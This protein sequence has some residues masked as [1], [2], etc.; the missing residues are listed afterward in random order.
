M[1]LSEFAELMTTVADSLR[2]QGDV[3]STLALITAGAVEAIPGVTHAS[4][5][6]AG[7]NGTIQTLT[8]T[9]EVA[10]LADRTQYELRQGP[11]VE[12]A[13]N[14]QVVQAD[15]LGSDSRW[16]LYGPKAADL[17]LR[18]QLSFQFR[19]DP[20]VRGAL[21]LYA[22]EPAAFGPDAR[23]LGAMFANW[24]AVLLGWNSQG[25]S[26]SRA[27]ESRGEIGT[28]VGILM[29][30]YRLDQQRAFAFLVRT[31]QTQNVKLREIAAGIVTRTSAHAA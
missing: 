28:A 19:A 23:Y 21:N 8:P 16:P 3:D 17:G 31:S 6:V 18:S 29:E 12:A 24:V 25:T 7:K 20:L 5:S 10:D 22:D 26:L 14:A 1:E 4:L 2:Q 11:C 30:R 27:L 13:L 9:D 15:D